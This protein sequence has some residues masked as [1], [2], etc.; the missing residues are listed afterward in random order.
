MDYRPLCARIIANLRIMRLPIAA[1]HLSLADKNSTHIVFI[2]FSIE[3][4]PKKMRRPTIPPPEKPAEDLRVPIATVASAPGLLANAGVSATSTAQA[5]GLEPDWFGDPTQ[6]VS[7]TEIGA[8]LTECVRVTHDDSFPFRLGLAEGLTALTAVGY[9]AQ[10]SPDVRAALTIL[11]DHVHHFAGAIEIRKK[12]NLAYLEYWFLLPRIRG[13]S[14][15]VEAGM[16]IGVSILRQLCGPA[17][18]PIEVQLTRR[19]PQRASEWQGYARA[20]VQF[21]AKRNLLVFSAKWLDHR[22]ERANAEFQHI[23]L[24]YMDGADAGRSYDLS[25]RVGSV[26]RETLLIGDG[27]SRQ[28]ATRLGVS[29]R[30][31]RRHLSGQGTSFAAL[32]DRTRFELACHFLENSTA[33]VTQIADLLGYAHASALSR[34]FRRWT[35]LSPRDW[36]AQRI[37]D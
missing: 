35:G 34:A 1:F 18:R 23:L 4:K 7:F 13:A 14:L 28:V 29:P 25:L 26:I 30:T 2:C 6:T 8:Y 11:R 15:I 32:Q 16:G 20:P 37:T 33:S 21:G 19:C 5:A 9:L 3:P 12:D 10:H 22:L 17:W 31:L 36:R 24:E 27:S